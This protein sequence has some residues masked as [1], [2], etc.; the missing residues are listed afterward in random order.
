ML[1]QYDYEYDFAGRITAI[2][3]LID[4]RSEFSFSTTDQLT[5]ADHDV[6]SSASNHNPNEV[7]SYDANGNRIGSGFIVDAQNR[8]MSDGVY[9]YQYDAEGNRIR[10]TLIADGSYEVNTF[11]HRHRLVRVDF[12]NASD[13]LQQSVTYA[14]DAFNRMVRRSVDNNGDGH[15]DRDQFF[16]GFDGDNSTLE[17]DGP[18]VS[19]LA[20]RRLWG[21]FIDQL[22]ASEEVDSLTVPGEV[23]WPVTDHTGT[24][25][26]VGRLDD[27]SGDFLIASHRVYSSFG[28]LT[29][30]Y[31]PA[32]GTAS[33]VDLDYGFTARFTD[34][35]TGMTHHQFRWYDPQLGKWI[36]EDPLGFAAGDINTTRYVANA[37][38]TY[39][40]PTGLIAVSI[41]DGNDD[42]NEGIAIN[43]GGQVYPLP[44]AGSGGKRPPLLLKK[45]LFWEGGF[46]R[47]QRDNCHDA[48]CFALAGHRLGV[49]HSGQGT[50]IARHPHLGEG[51]R[52]FKTIP[53]AF[54]FVETQVNRGIRVRVFV[55][56][57]NSPNR[58]APADFA[59]Q[60]PG[61]LSPQEVDLRRLY[62]FATLHWRNRGWEWEWIN[63]G[64][65]N[66][67]ARGGL[68]NYRNCFVGVI[69]V[70]PDNPRL[71]EV[72]W[73]EPSPRP[74]PGPI[75]NRP[76]SG[77]FPWEGIR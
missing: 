19:D 17:F 21:P 45:T 38:L 62:N 65:T 71:P 59:P 10:R 46:T 13:L 63:N 5:D 50:T 58:P 12:Y 72:P 70:S 73:D 67:L 61:E 75:P 54:H 76:T 53:A 29:D 23:Y 16:A 6:H 47:G 4:G 26:D 69:P 24:I 42:A 49:Y 48:G 44:T 60:Y 52:L 20:H 66:E 55:I 11:D 28:L 57:T 77:G 68:P 3:S 56:Q 64:R 18:D 8:T 27:V 7:Y 14:Y 30:E 31:D 1:A 74:G 32:T 25:R 34:P 9:D 43:I 2:D 40:D 15:A 41:G 39:T 51:C 22:I 37:P 36:S 33:G 35:L